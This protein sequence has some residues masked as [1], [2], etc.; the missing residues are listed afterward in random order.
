MEMS[1][2]NNGARFFLPKADFQV[3]KGVRG[4]AIFFECEPIDL[5]TYSI[6]GSH[7]ISCRYDIF[8][9]LSKREIAH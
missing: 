8:K 2:K 3:Q 6:F 4:R 5:S 7:R 9:Y 1:S